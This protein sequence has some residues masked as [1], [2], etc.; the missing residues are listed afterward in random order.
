MNQSSNALDSSQATFFSKAIDWVVIHRT[1]I[2]VFC[3][4][5]VAG[6]ASR[7]LMV[8]EPNFKPIA[9]L[10]LFAGFYFGR[11]TVGIAAL[12]VTMLISD[13]V[14]GF[15]EPSMMLAV[16]ASLA[17]CCGLGL[18]CRKSLQGRNV[19]AKAF[20]YFAISS[21][22]MSCVF[23]VATNFAVWASGLWYPNTFEGLTSCFVAA[24]PFF[25]NTVASDFMFSQ[26]LMAVYGIVVLAQSRRERSV[27]IT[28]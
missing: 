9:A 7:I 19:S 12:V 16:Y 15:Y 21:L 13:L 1:S 22:A 5:V 4:I 6:I 28:V 27:S 23:F 20:G 11:A 2:I 17:V 25:R 24:I 8:E 18:L 3:L 10:I 14:F 26:G